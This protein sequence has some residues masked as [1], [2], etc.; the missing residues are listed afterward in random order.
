[1]IANIGSIS[2]MRPRSGNAFAFLAA[3]ATRG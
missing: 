1:M 2:P 3:G